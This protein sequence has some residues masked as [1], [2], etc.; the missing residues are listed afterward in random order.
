MK[1][2]INFTQLVEILDGFECIFI[3]IFSFCLKKKIEI[4]QAANFAARCSH[5]QHENID[6]FDTVNL[7]FK[8]FLS[9]DRRYFVIYYSSRR[10]DKYVFKISLENGL[11]PGDKGHQVDFPKE[12]A[13]SEFIKKVSLQK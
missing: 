3:S 4:E 10:N 8:Y 6:G 12:S 7:N 9:P 1:R 11:Q 13:L 5:E 2:K